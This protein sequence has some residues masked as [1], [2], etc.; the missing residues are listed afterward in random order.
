ME[1]H[2]VQNRKENCH[3]DHI[4]LNVKG[5]IVFSVW[6]VGREGGG[7]SQTSPNLMR[8]TMAAYHKFQFRC[9]SALT[10]NSSKR[11]KYDEKKYSKYFA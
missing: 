3:H 11:Q 8:A 2:L 4:P 10:Q 6:S 7:A 1:F 9:L 5:N